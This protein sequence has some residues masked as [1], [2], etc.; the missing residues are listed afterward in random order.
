MQKSNMGMMLSRKP[1]EV[2][3]TMLLK[4]PH[5]K[6][7]TRTPKHAATDSTFMRMAFKGSTME[8]NI[9]KSRI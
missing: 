1:W 7:K 6:M 2:K 8:R 3:P 9:N 5:W 4:L